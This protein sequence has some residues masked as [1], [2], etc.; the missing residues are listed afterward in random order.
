MASYY[1][2]HVHVSIG[3]LK[4]LASEVQ[5]GRNELT[6]ASSGPER[7]QP[8]FIRLFGKSHPFLIGD[9]NTWILSA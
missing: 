5:Q 2:V 8:E 3:S 7:V 4:Y 6:R 9:L 1:H